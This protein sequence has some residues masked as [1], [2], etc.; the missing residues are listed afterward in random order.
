MLTGAFCWAWTRVDAPTTSTAKVIAATPEYNTLPD[1]HL[2]VPP[3]L[4]LQ[5]FSRTP[6]GADR[7]LSLHC[8]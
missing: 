6:V 4:S 8:R 7:A 1:A 3:L 2:D 5:L